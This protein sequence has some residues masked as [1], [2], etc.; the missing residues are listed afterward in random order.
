MT[1]GLDNLAQLKLPGDFVLAGQTQEGAAIVGIGIT[2]RSP[3]LQNRYLL[4]ETYQGQPVIQVGFIDDKRSLTVD[5]LVLVYEALCFGKTGIA[6]GN[7]N[8]T[9]AMLAS[10]EVKKGKGLEGFEEVAQNWEPKTASPYH[11][12]IPRVFGFLPFNTSLNYGLGIVRATKESVRQTA[13]SD[14]PRKDGMGYLL[15]SA[16]TI[17]LKHFTGDPLGIELRDSSAKDI[18]KRVYDSLDPNFRVAVAVAMVRGIEVTK[19][20]VNRHN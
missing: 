13:Y 18:A 1:N 8:H 15:P 6:V 7:G 17:T 2:E 4:E 14:I 5:P 16:G 11:L 19:A 9:R 12:T 10:I 20:I 3:A